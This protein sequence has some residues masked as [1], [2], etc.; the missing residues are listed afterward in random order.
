[1][2]SDV[3]D[4]SLQLFLIH[5]PVRTVCLSPDN[6]FNIRKASD[7]SVG[8]PRIFPPHNTK[9]SAVTRISESL[10]LRPNPD[11]FNLARC[12][13]TRLISIEDSNSS[14]MS[15]LTSTVNS[16]STPSSSNLL[17]GDEEA[18]TTL[19]F[20]SNSLSIAKN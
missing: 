10:S 8:F 5:T 14:G 17:L 4:L 2:V 12:S 13:G 15:L 7:L 18:R 6:I 19:L 11:D 20:A 3:N 16:R 1:M 9:V